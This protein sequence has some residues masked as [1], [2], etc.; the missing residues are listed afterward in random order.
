MRLSK[1]AVCAAAVTML[2]LTSA[3]I[4]ES[5]VIEESPVVESPVIEE[6]AVLAPVDD[7]SFVVRDAVP[8]RFF[9]PATSGKD[10]LNPNRLVIGF[11]SGM[12]WTTWKATDFRASS[13][14]YSYTTAMDTLHVTITAA[15]ECYCYISKITYSQKGTGAV[16]RIGFAGGAANWV[17]EGVAQNLGTFA[18]NPTLSRSMVPAGRPTTVSMSVTVNL[19]SFATSSL[20]AASLLLREADVLVEV[21][22]L[23]LE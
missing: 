17:V 8:N 13:A 6:S 4:A 20:G 2:M 22:P 1:W 3:G 15:K 19:S 9:D 12:D 18:T 23:P 16:A 5:Q 10:P 21:L 7:I 14:A 11:H